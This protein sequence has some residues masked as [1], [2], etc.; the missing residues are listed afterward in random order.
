MQPK[1][2]SYLKADPKEV[3]VL[4]DSCIAHCPQPIT[5]DMAPYL[6][7]RA[8]VNMNA[9]LYRA[10]MLDYDAYFAAVRW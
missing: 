10:A 6:L 9:E 1:R 8:Q 3:I 5:A 7:E 2:K 4:L